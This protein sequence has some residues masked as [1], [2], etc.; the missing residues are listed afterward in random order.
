[1]WDNEEITFNTSSEFLPEHNFGDGIPDDFIK[2]QNNKITTY[3]VA[4]SNAHN[5]SPSN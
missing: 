2:L 4:Y 5:L 3:E 1:M